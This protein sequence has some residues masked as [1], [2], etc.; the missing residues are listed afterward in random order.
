MNTSVSVNLTMCCYFSVKFF[1]ELYE[2]NSNK[3][4]NDLANHHEGYFQDKMK[5][6]YLRDIND[7]RVT[8]NFS[9]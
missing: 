4:D 3:M 9:F 7:T 2:Q 6:Y 1:T 8:L 5:F